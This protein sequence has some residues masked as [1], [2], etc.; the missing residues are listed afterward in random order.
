MC[1]RVWYV[2][3]AYGI[4]KRMVQNRDSK[5]A[6]SAKFLDIVYK[7]YGFSADLIETIN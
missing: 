7:S 5:I 2:P 1:I 3:Y 4:N 6:T